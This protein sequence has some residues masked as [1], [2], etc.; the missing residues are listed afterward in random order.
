M[1][2]MESRDDVDSPCLHAGAGA[3]AGL[4]WGR[5]AATQC[6]MPQRRDASFVWPALSTVLCT[7]TRPHGP[8]PS[9]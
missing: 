5:H 2:G 6:H 9:S 7:G 3:G 4:G 1:A 8:Q